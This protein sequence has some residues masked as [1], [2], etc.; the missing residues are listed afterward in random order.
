MQLFLIGT[1]W[2]WALILTASGLIIYCLEDS[3]DELQ[4]SASAGGI[5][6]TAI[7]IVTIIVFGIFGGKRT[8][9]DI[10]EYVKNN[11]VITISLIFLYFVLGIVWSFV[12]WYFFL[13]KIKIYLLKTTKKGDEF[14]IYTPKVSD[15]KSKITTW[16]TYWPLSMFW[17][18]IDEPIKNTFKFIFGKIEKSYQKLSD[19]MFKDL[20]VSKNK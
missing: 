5:E 7:S 12:K 17:T 13:N 8:L 14:S 18:M 2:F 11:P 10:L 15:H 19:N 9:I 6:A 16:M 4:N 20:N 3:L 1:F